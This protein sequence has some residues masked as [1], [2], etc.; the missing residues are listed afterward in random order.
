MVALPGIWGMEALDSKVTYAQG[1]G[2]AF[3]NQNEADMMHDALR[4][5]VLLAKQS[6]ADGTANAGE[7][8]AGIK[9]H[10]QR[11]ERLMRENKEIDL[12]KSLHQRV[13]DIEPH[14]TAYYA[15][16]MATVKAAIEDP[17]G[18]GA[19]YASFQ[20]RFEDM[21]DR[22]EELADEIQKVQATVGAEGSAIKS[23]AGNVLYGAAVAALVIAFLSYW[24]TRNT[25]IA[26]LITI[27]GKMGKL[28]KGNLNIDIPYLDNK[29]EIGDMARALQVF[30]NNAV[31][32]R[33]L[34]A[35]QQEGE[36]ASRRERQAAVT[37]LADDFEAHVGAIVGVVASSSGELDASAN[38]MLRMA[39]TAKSQSSIVAS[40]SDV[41]TGSV[42]TAASAAEELS[43]SVN[44]ISRQV[45]RSVEIATAAVEEARKTDATVQGLAQA[46]EKIGAVVKM[47][48]DIAA[49]TNLLA[50]NATI[51]AA[52]AGEAGKGFAVVAA[53]VKSL[54]NQTARATEEIAT[55]IAASQTVTHKAVEAIRAIGTRIGEMD[56]IASAIRYA[57]EEQGQ[58]TREIAHSIAQ[59]ASGSAQVNQAI[60]SVSQAAGQTGDAASRLQVASGT[61]SE[62][63]TR[64]RREV[65]NFLRSVRVAG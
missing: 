52:R 9:E 42:Q 5:D 31:E 51:E 7:I 35:Q 13:V 26:P 60:G 4:A 21:E 25:I 15:E 28:A 23:T 20:R 36:A 34:A 29:D 27:E 48:S 2:L 18:F 47:I 58:A 56:Q 19:K 33:R 41:A 63:S 30:K 39:E 46:S 45:A 40:A 32:M 53:E 64:L 55:Q 3:G 38:A 61:L 6:V 8:Y 14:V 17:A 44:E 57:V 54:A 65:D 10:G 43:A 59:A 37:K 24:F 16:A 62:Q 49:Q 11:F 1:I 22:M 12:P 50:L